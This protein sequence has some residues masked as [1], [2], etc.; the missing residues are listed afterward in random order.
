M[1]END[2]GLTGK[3]VNAG[4]FAVLREFKKEIKSLNGA[5]CTCRLCRR[6]IPQLGFL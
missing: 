1:I 6:Y 5:E 3:N 4:G 2:A